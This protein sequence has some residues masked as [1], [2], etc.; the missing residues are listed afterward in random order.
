MINQM[1]AHGSTVYILKDNVLYAFDN[2]S[3]TQKLDEVLQDVTV[4]DSS[5][6]GCIA[7]KSD[8]TIWYCGDSMAGTNTIVN[9]FVDVS[10]KFK[11]IT[12]FD[13]KTATIKKTYYGCMVLVP[14]TK[15]IWVI[16]HNAYG[17]LG[18]GVGSYKMEYPDFVQNTAVDAV[19]IKIQAHVSYYKDST[20]KVFGCGLDSGQLQQGIS[21][22][23]SSYVEVLYDTTET[24][25]A[26]DSVVFKNAADSKYYAL[27]NSRNGQMGDGYGFPKDKVNSTP[28][29]VMDTLS[30]DVIDNNIYDEHL[31]YIK[32]WVFYGFGKILNK[33]YP[34]LTNFTPFT[35]LN[36]TPTMFSTNQNCILTS[37][38]N[39][40]WYIGIMDGKYSSDWAEIKFPSTDAMDIYLSQ[41]NNRFMTVN[42]VNTDKSINAFI[43]SSDTAFPIY[44]SDNVYYSSTT[45]FGKSAIKVLYDE[46]VWYYG[47]A[48]I[49]GVKGKTVTEWTDCTDL[50]K[51]VR[52][53]SDNLLQCTFMTTSY[54]VHVL[55]PSSQLYAI[56]TSYKADLGIF[57][58]AYPDP[59]Y[60]SNSDDPNDDNDFDNATKYVYFP[61]LT[62][63]TNNK[64]ALSMRSTYYFNTY[65]N[66]NDDLY[67]C[68]NGQG[69]MGV[70]KNTY[71]VDFAKVPWYDNTC[72]ILAMQ[73]GSIMV[74]KGTDKK[75]YTIGWAGNSE[76]GQTVKVLTSLTEVALPDNLTLDDIV[77]FDNV[78]D[79]DYSYFITKSGDFYGSGSFKDGMTGTTGYKRDS[80][81]KFDKLSLPSGVAVKDIT[82]LSGTA[83]NLIMTVN[84]ADVYYTGNAKYIIDP[85]KDVVMN[86]WSSIFKPA[87]IPVTD[88]NIIPRTE[89]IYCGM[90]GVP[91]LDIE[92]IPPDAT[93][94]VLDK[95]R[96]NS[97]GLNA[98][99][100]VSY[101]PVTDTMNVPYLSSNSS[102]GA[103]FHYTVT[104]EDGSTVTK[105][106][107]EAI[108]EIFYCVF[109][110]D[111]LT[112]NDVKLNIQYYR[113]TNYNLNSF[114][115]I[116]Q[117]EI[118]ALNP[119]IMV[120]LT[121]KGTDLVQWDENNLQW[122]VLH[123]GASAA[124][125]SSTTFKLKY[126]KYFTQYYLRSIT[127]MTKPSATAAKKMKSSSD[128]KD[129]DFG[130]L[131]GA[132]IST[133]E[134]TKT[135]TISD[136]VHTNGLI[137][138]TMPV[139][140]TTYDLVQTFSDP[141]VD[142]TSPD[143]TSEIFSYHP[144]D[145]MLA[146]VKVATNEQFPFPGT[147]SDD[148]LHITDIPYVSEPYYMQ[149]M[150]DQTWK[151]NTLIYDDNNNL[152]HVY[153]QVTVNPP[154]ISGYNT[155]DEIDE[156]VGDFPVLF[157]YNPDIVDQSS[158]DFT[159]T[160]LAS[161]VGWT[162]YQSANQYTW[163][164]KISDDG[165]TVT[166]PPI[167]E[168]MVL[169]YNVNQTWKGNPIMRKERKPV[170]ENPDIYVQLIIDPVYVPA[171]HCDD[172]SDTAK[173]GTT[174]NVSLPLTPSTASPYD[175]LLTTRWA[176]EIASNPSKGYDFMTAQHSG[177]QQV[178]SG[179][180][181]D[182]GL[183]IDINSD[184]PEG[185]LYIYNDVQYDGTAIG[186]D[187]IP[188]P[189]V[190]IEL[191]ITK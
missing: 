153:I 93:G 105:D 113:N 133:A 135:F 82:S 18:M 53:V 75:L 176:K 172:V 48:S 81:T 78:D 173:V 147:I 111:T 83:N 180:I 138:D 119:E 185:W 69:V 137:T 100:N 106:S 179:T 25:A 175:P 17:E 102:I 109:P 131:V 89:H 107:V 94:W 41:S 143:F 144:D 191:Q 136:P 129:L 182:D 86:A 142:V 124:G 117:S 98:Q 140:A 155:D 54:G 19:E 160:L 130:G 128:F 92:V 66:D 68:G 148:G 149:W 77:M 181:S 38:G 166:F 121:K 80:Y 104:N 73:S 118:D 33:I 37:D 12:K 145:F 150:V 188:P 45:K 11:S 112:G 71:Y 26:R 127:G 116:P 22:V 20:G 34:V 167:L 7:V 49:I 84:G 165:L 6:K 67:L 96:F 40:A 61:K 171:T 87:T 157:T 44:N 79:T 39:S 31:A 163:D 152:G 90:Q 183:T 72:E 28:V 59:I 4:F 115:P 32:G 101:D 14:E 187:L 184:C 62:K 57:S 51:A 174:Y 23:K 65:I 50:F 164:G 110:D 158:S 103:S 178:F 91:T 99:S 186:D 162:S 170:L 76:N 52:D 29:K 2:Y 88:F 97:T 10:A 141:S 177:D 159:S 139:N 1:Q 35:S 9:A 15:S 122:D 125:S 114:A 74:K 123:G 3:S 36:V 24:Y 5:P 55:T 108:Q 189:I 60:N 46:T 126:D 8:G 132:G 58:T 27:G 154:T 42:S 30:Y 151:G 134:V 64:H 120:E 168:K 70:T 43:S 190:T 13:A 56:G 156:P 85:T 161:T 16:G 21:G 146:W 95:V 169:Y 63:V 47:E